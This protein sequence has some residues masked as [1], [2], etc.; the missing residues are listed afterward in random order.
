MRE[1]PYWAKRTIPWIFVVVGVLSAWYVISITPLDLVLS[2]TFVLSAL[3]FALVTRLWIPRR[4]PIKGRKKG[5]PAVIGTGALA[6]IF[7]TVYAIGRV[8]KD[9]FLPIA[10]GG[11]IGFALLP[12]VLL[13]YD[14]T[15]GTRL[16]WCDHCKTHKVFLRYKGEWVC[17]VCARRRMLGAESLAKPQ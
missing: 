10:A 11:F 8:W 13:I 15:W 7:L 6:A 5:R 1:L 3:G 12:T 17:S 16:L 4:Q 2:P 9:A 14:L